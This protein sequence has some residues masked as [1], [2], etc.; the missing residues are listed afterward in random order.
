MSKKL[1]PEPASNE[2][3]ALLTTPLQ[4]RAFL[5]Y[6]GAGL[7][8]TGL[9]L[10]S[11]CDDDNDDPSTNNLVN[12]G[13]EDIGVLN[14]AY[15][16]EQLEFAFYT[17]VQAGNYYKG[18]SPTS[19]EKQV[20]DDLTLHEKAH[21]DFLRNA[22]GSNAIKSLEADFSAINFGERSAVLNAAKTFEDLGVAAYN[23][24]GR[25]IKQAPNLVLAGKIVSVEARHAA[26]IRDILQY[27]SFVGADVVDLYT[28]GTGGVGSGTV[29]TGKERSLKPSQVVVSANAYLKEGSKLNVSQL[30]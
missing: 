17:Q 15:A 23:G 26:L 11:S 29:G 21:V 3:G 5:R 25:Y 30:G 22:L 10:T 1:L 19:A 18:L 4:R 9:A 24:A 16:L 2:A 13:S 28:P 14:Y 12:V 20:L 27:N 7:A 6:S 8:L